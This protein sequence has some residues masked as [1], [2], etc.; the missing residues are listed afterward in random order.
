[1]STMTMST[2]APMT[3]LPTAARSRSA[4]PVRLTRRGRLVV[5]VVALL[6]LLAVGIAIAGGSMATDEAGTPEP[7]RVVMVGSGETLWAIAAEVADDG[8]VREMVQRISRLNAL[9]T[10]MVQAGQRL[11]VPTQP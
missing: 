5:F 4:A 7:T 6:M 8:D 10:A 11:R 2:T 9:E 3:W 1:M